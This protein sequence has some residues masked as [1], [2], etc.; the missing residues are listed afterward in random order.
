MNI[1]VSSCR[2]E[3]VPETNR[4]RQRLE[5]STSDVITIVDINK[6]LSINI[7]TKRISVCHCKCQQFVFSIIQNIITYSSSRSNLMIFSRTIYPS[8]TL[9]D[10]SQSAFVRYPVGSAGSVPSD[11]IGSL[12]SPGCRLMTMFGFLLEMP[13]GS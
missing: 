8:T 3:R 7:K 1:H 11:V 5:G 13:Q 10:H 4:P 12:C 9:T 6:I 2:K